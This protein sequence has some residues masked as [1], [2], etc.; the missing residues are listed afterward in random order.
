MLNR[1]K[2]SVRAL[3]FLYKCYLNFESCDDVYW[4]MYVVLRCC[5]GV[6]VKLLFLIH[7]MIG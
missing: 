6:R 2:R 4:L 1:K 7:V 5:F 3:S